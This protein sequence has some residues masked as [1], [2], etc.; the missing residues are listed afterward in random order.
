MENNELIKNG[1]YEVIKNMVEDWS[2]NSTS[3][4]DKMAKESI[5]DI[6]GE[7]IRK[8]IKETVEKNVDDFVKSEVNICKESPFTISNGWSSETITIQ[9]MVKKEIRK[10]VDTY[11]IQRIITDVVKDL[12]KNIVNDNFRKDMKLGLENTLDKSINEVFGVK[13]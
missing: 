6:C 5:R 3:Y 13:Q 9:E 4:I 7:E 10:Q 12:V 8:T 2:S 11:N 1:F